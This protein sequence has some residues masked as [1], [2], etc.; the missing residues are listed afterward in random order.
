LK[1]KNKEVT[2]DR[3]DL[4]ILKALQENSR[5][6]YTTIG[7]RL[8][9]AHSTVYD[10]VRKMEEQKII[11][12]YTTLVDL[13]KAGVPSVLAIVTIYTDPKETEGVAEKLAE[14]SQ[15]LE[16]YTSLSD[17][18]LIMAK[19]LAGSQEELHEFIAN[20]VA[21]LQGVLRIRTSIITKKLKETHFSIMNYSKRL[22]L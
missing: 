4:E 18:L 14:S 9:I 6:T 15:V 12:S 10:R 5:Q 13:E 20:W 19:V 22:H 16:V 11:K 1:L 17:E 8:R 2:L 3:A 21:P 7:K